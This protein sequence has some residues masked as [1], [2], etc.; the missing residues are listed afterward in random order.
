M[1][2]INWGLI[3]IRVLPVV[4]I[5]GILILWQLWVV[6]DN[7]PRY[8]LPSP[9]DVGESMS[10]NWKSLIRHGRVTLVE[11]LAGFGMSVA[12]G[13]PLAVAIVYSKI[14]ENMLYPL[15]V[16]SQAIPK[17]AI[18]P[19]LL[20]WLGFGIAPK[21]VVAF[22]IAFFP[23]VVTTASGL[24]GVT[25]DTLQLVRSMGATTWQVF[26]RVRFPTAVPSMLAGFK[27]AV[28]LSVVGAVVGEFVGANEGL[29]YYVLVASGNFDTSLLFASVMVL[30]LMGVVLF[31]SIA[32]VE[33]RLNRWVAG[34]ESNI[35][36]EMFTA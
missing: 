18:A 30:T 10:E 14:F 26:R 12:I 33:T 28:A 35:R 19:L 25:D 15:L 9:I 20:V 11:T 17:I 8:L 5:I 22:L 2:R 36:A 31:Y 4:T 34:G 7:T 21:V 24:R 3:G 32:V 13:V 1:K 27:V 23:V 16:G 29:G 6:V